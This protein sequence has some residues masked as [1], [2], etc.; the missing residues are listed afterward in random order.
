MNDGRTYVREEYEETGKG[1]GTMNEARTD[2]RIVGKIRQDVM[3]ISCQRSIHVNQATTGEIVGM[4]LQALQVEN[5]INVPIEPPSYKGILREVR[6]DNQ[7][8][9]AS[10]DMDTPQQVRKK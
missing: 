4:E 6:S 1:R 2:L 5:L 8:I 3:E 9:Q 10:Q 7:G